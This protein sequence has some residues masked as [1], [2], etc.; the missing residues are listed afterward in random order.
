[1]FALV[2]RLD[3]VHVILAIAANQGL[4]VYHL[5]VKPTFLNGE[6]EEE[7]Y[8]TQP[9]GFVVKNK[10]HLVLKIRKVLYGLPQ[11]PRTWNIRLDRSLKQLG[12]V[13]CAQDL[14]VYTRGTGRHGIIV[15]VYVDDLIVIGESPE[16]I[17][18]FKQQMM[19]EF[20]MTNL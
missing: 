7:V 20:E 1:M 15:G 9:E 17:M 4:Q 12:F 14:V 13:K 11:A 8:V 6:L 19:S 5:N 2:T 10:E 18:G 16:E 3:T